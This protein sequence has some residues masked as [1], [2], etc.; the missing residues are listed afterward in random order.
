MG[1]LV[2]VLLC[3]RRV[4]LECISYF[5]SRGRSVSQEKEK[6]MALVLELK[7]E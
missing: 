5:M 2:I 1:V 3:L 6:E 7:Q 4:S